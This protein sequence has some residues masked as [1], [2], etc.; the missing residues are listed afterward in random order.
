MERRVDGLST[1]K[2]DMMYV[3][4]VEIHDVWI[5]LGRSEEGPDQ[6]HLPGTVGIYL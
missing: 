6:K 5:W 4:W 1:T 3:G 2:L